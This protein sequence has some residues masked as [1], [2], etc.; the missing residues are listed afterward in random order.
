[1]LERLHL[2]VFLGN[3]LFWGSFLV[4][5]RLLPLSLYQITIQLFFRGFRL[6]FLIFFLFCLSQKFC[7]QKLSA[8]IRILTNILFFFNFTLKTTIY[9]KM[10]LPHHRFY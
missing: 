9:I 6:F 1:M 2:Q 8:K 4:F 7:P 10:T 3:N 5:W